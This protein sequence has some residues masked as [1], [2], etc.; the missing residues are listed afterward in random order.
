MPF[1]TLLL[2]SIG[3]DHV[4]IESCYKGTTFMKILQEYDHFMVIFL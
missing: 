4:I 3:M 2:G 1:I